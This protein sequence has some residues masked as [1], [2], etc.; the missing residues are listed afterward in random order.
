MADEVTASAAARPLAAAAA[1]VRTESSTGLS[2]R[3][4]ATLAYL[5]WWVTG[6]LFWFIERR[7]PFVRF[8]AAQACTAFGLVATF[9]LA[10]LV[11]A[12]ASLSFVPSAFG[13]FLWAAA[14]TW[15]GGLVLWAAAM[16]MAGSG[17]MWRI[18]LAAELADRVARK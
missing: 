3:V 4:A 2:P 7:D 15:V 14:V 12:V 16:W 6:V 11:L 17:R 10:F 8:H 18:P 1:S 5:G 9:I 13:P